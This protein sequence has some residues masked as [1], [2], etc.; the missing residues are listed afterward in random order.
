MVTNFKFLFFLIF[1]F[2][3]SIYA[4]DSDFGGSS[5]GSTGTVDF[6]LS[7]G[8]TQAIISNSNYI[9]YN[10]TV[11]LLLPFD[12]SS[13]FSFGISGK[14]EALT[15]S[16][17]PNSN[18]NG[19]V[20]STYQA[21]FVGLDLAYKLTFSILDI[22][23]NPYAYYGVYNY[24]NRDTNFNGSIISGNPTINLN[25]LYGAG[26]SFLFKLGFLYFG[27]A[28]YYSRGYLEAA[29]YNDTNG[30]SFGQNTG[31]Y[32]ILDLNFSLGLFL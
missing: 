30:N 3:S 26:L 9:G 29:A 22:Q 8:Y 20:T 7:G 18:S 31:N 32:Q 12:R 6:L 17:S 21:A 10:G 5:S 15:S 1:M 2:F 13:N 16:D 14:Y 24:W 25:V 23:F 19:V 28:A 11:K 27:P 4:Q